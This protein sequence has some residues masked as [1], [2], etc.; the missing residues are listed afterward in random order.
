MPQHDSTPVSPTVSILTLFFTVEFADR[1][2]RLPRPPIP[3]RKLDEPHLPP[4]LQYRL[5]PL[6]LPP[7][8]F[9]HLV[10]IQPVTAENIIVCLSA[11]YTSF[12]DSWTR[13][14][15]R[16]RRRLYK[17]NRGFVS[18]RTAEVEETIYRTSDVPPVSSISGLDMREGQY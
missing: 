10:Y 2:H 5:P 8:A 18:R 4:P 11:I 17:G 7:R 14:R 9:T 6:L 15:Y 3:L 12:D 1:P 13:A 16:K